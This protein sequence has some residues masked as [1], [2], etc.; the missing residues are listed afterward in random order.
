MRINLFRLTLIAPPIL[1]ACAPQI[2][3]ERPVIGLYGCEQPTAATT[4]SHDRERGRTT[5][6]HETPHEEPHDRED[7]DR[8]HGNDPDRHDEDNPGRGRM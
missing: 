8:G 1:A 3:C 6:E 5:P 2:T 7:R 4:P